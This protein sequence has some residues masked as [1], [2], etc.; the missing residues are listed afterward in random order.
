[1][2][3]PDVVGD[4]D[5]VALAAD[6]VAGRTPGMPSGLVIDGAPRPTRSGATRA[7]VSPRDGA[8]L[9]VLPWAAV[10]DVDDAVA[11]ARSAFRDGP[12]TRLHPRER[13]E[14]MVEFARVIDAH[15]S[16]LALSLIHI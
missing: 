16:E 12:W 10:D 3:A 13:G 2:S 14:L 5:W 1:M 7:I 8:T 11:S 9:T 15:R 4:T 6:V